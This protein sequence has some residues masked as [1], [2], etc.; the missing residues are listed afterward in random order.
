MLNV[1]LIKVV[2]LSQNWFQHLYILVKRAQTL[3]ILM[4][5]NLKHILFDAYEENKL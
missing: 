2:G 1:K 3:R 5:I 4:I